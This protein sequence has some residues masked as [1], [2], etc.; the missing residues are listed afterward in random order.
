MRIA[1]YTDSFFPYL[2]G[3]ATAV[4]VLAEAL[5]EVGHEVFIQAPRPKNPV[6]LSFLP[7]NVHVHF[8]PSIDVIIYPD[9]R[10]GTNIPLFLKDLK[11][12]S[13]DIIHVH[14]PLSV[15]LEGYI[16]AKR[17]GLPLIQTFH[18]YFMDE[19]ALRVIGVRN[20]R[21]ARLLNHGGWRFNRVLSQLCDATITPTHYVA[22]DLRSH[23]TPGPIL[24]C[25][26]ML[27]ADSFAR[28]PDGKKQ[29]RTLLFVG[30]LSPEK[31]VDLLL[32]SFAL[33]RKKI[34]DLELTLIGDGPERTALFHLSLE[35]GISE[36][37]RWY[38]AIPHQELLDR[39]LYHQGDVFVTLSRFETF[40]YTTLEA[41][42]HQLPVIALRSKANTEVVGSAGFLIADTPDPE[43][44]VKRAAKMI[45]SVCDQDL[46]KLRQQAL[47][48]AEKYQPQTLLPDYLSAYELAI[49]Q[50]RQK[51]EQA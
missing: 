6:D 4:L 34:S 28:H 39:R 10:I 25:P 48:Q 5:S 11:E 50:H 9:M 17:L 12:F 31:R 20:H 16:T 30:R 38:G 22:K 40:G 14:T 27:S 35:L 36:A 21:L 42:A 1:M 8:V 26:N 37:V 51:K 47:A 33:A 43:L 46:S 32:R 44:A 49:E 24:V 23:Q 41:L 19:T 2:S 15:G 7:K 18:T 3:V 45:I 13:P 29:A